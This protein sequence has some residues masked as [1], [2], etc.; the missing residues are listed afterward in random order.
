MDKKI[1]SYYFYPLAALMLTACGGG[2]S[3]SGSS[4]ADV[5][6]QCL[7]QRANLF[8][9]Q[10]DFT[11]NFISVSQGGQVTNIGTAEADQFLITVLD[12]Q[13]IL[14]CMDPSEPNGVSSCS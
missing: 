9:N 4:S 10:C 13:Q 1:H 11:V 6:A 8:F 7:E 2:S 12:E 3:S 5:T 14:L